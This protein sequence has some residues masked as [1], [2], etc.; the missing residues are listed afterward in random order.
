MK[1]ARKATRVQSPAPVSVPAPSQASHAAPVQTATTPAAATRSPAPAPAATPTPTPAA[2]ESR[3]V[4]NVAVPR[5]GAY[6]GLLSYMPGLTTKQSVEHREQQFSRTFDIDS[7]YYDWTDN[8]PGSGEA[9]DLARGRI[10]M[11][12]WWGTTYASI[13]DGSQDA[14]IHRAAHSL[15]AFAKPVYLRWAAEMNGDWFAWGGPENGNDPSGFVAAWRR[16]HDIFAADGVTNVSWVWAPNADSSPGG[17]DTSSWN[18][19]RNYYPGDAYVD[20]VGIDGYNWGTTLCAACWQ[21]FGEIMD[22]IYRDYGARKPI[23]VAETASTESG[24]NKAAWI[25]AMRT[26]VKS[27]PAV[28]AVVWFDRTYTSTGHDWALDTSAASTTAFGALAGDPYFN[29]RG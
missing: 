29:V 5:S 27:H 19:W 21:S 18:N 12:T 1:P 26:W 22:P 9:A 23:M 17:V 3:P 2:S 8:L 6:L 14:L 20:W 7:H 28:K 15:K 11:I 13:N 25:G 16:I 4:S 10:P 24:G